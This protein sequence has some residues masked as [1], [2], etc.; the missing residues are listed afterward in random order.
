MYEKFY[1][2][3][4]KPFQI[5]PNPAYLYSSEKHNKALTYVEYGLRQNIG[6]I[7]LS[8]EVGS[9]KTMLIQ[10]I[11]TGLDPGADVALISNTNISPGQ[12]LVMILNEFELPSE[13]INKA[14]ALNLLNQFLIK[15][16][17]ERRQVLLIIDEAQHL[18]PEALEEVRM[19][20]N[21][22]SDDQPLLQILI[23]GQPELVAKLKR[24]ALRQFAQRIAVSF[25]L[26]G[27]DREDTGKYIAF[28]L[29]K[30]GGR[31]DLFT[32]HAVDR[33]FELS[34]GIPR[35]I[36]LVCQAALVYGFADEASTISQDIVKQIAEDKVGVGPGLNSNGDDVSE[37]ADTAGEA[38]T[39]V[40]QQLQKMEGEIQALRRQMH[41]RTTEQ[42]QK[43]SGNRKE[44]VERLN[45]LLQEERRQNAT[46]MRRYRRLELKYEALLRVKTRLQEKL[47]SALKTQN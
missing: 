36:N 15:R 46:L 24:P 44:L 19:L 31:P 42:Q 6:F 20:S 29:Q 12:L 8:G 41:T 38:S 35:S 26:T 17:G 18:S 11:L 40:L 16:Y 47:E 22:H 4:E 32:E 28:R 1:S 3:N 30:A 27:L 7:L 5:V 45:Q 21:L 25:H 34:G 13:N 2:F 37:T 43:A 14:A 39:G 33:V 23:V 10:Y 9:G